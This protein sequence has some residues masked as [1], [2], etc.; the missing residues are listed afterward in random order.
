MSLRYDSLRARLVWPF[1]LLGYAVSAVLSLASFTIFSALEERAIDRALVSEL[2]SFRFR[3][4]HHPDALPPTAALLKGVRL[5]SAELPGISPIVPDVQK[6]ERLTVN[7]TRYS[8]LIAEVGGVPYA[9]AYDRTRT[10]A[11]LGR[12]ALFLL[13]ATAVLTMLSYAVGSYLARRLVSPITQLLDELD[14]KSGETDPHRADL[15]FLAADYPN[16]E[17]GD[18]VRS[19]DAFARRLQGFILRENHFAADVS[20]ELR[21]PVAVI[22]GAAEVMQA[23]SGMPAICQAKLATIQRSAA[24]MGELL[25]AMLLLSKEPGSG[26][27]PTCAIAEVVDDVLTDCRPSLERR[28]VRLEVNLRAQ[29]L[30]PVERSLAYVALS[31]VVRN[32][33]AHTEQGTIVIT[34][35]DDRLAIEDSG[36]GIPEDR[37]P[38]LF[39]R[40]VKGAESSGHGLGLSIVARVAQRL[41]WQVSLS[42]R[43][44]KGTRVEFSF[45][46]R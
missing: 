16:N 13:V 21:T 42:S 22:R 29:P 33:C 1:V 41:G 32:A 45:G 25:E 14:E 35:D 8:M 46:V 31:N 12:L 44:G 4:E 34:V 23:Q 2:E 36:G 20:H 18:L 7:E 15:G 9:L 3:V 40:H 28:P 19:I 10:D 38:S 6:I 5:P 17:I 11:G 30:L 37:F 39:E 24:R 27:D 26:D 43:S